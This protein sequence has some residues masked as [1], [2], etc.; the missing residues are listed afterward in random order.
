MFRRY[1]MMQACAE[2][3]ELVSVALIKNHAFMGV[4]GCL[5]NLFGL[6]PGEFHG[7]RPRHYYHHLV[8]MPY[9]LADLGRLYDP[10]LNIV[11]ALV[12]QAGQEW[13]DGEGAGRVVNGLIAGDHVV[14]TDA[15]M[16][17]I[18]G[19]DSRADWPQQPF[20]R[21]RNALKIA[22]DGGFGTVDLEQI[23]FE[24]EVEPAAEGT[25]YARRTDSA[26]TNYSWLRSMCEQAHY[27]QANRQEFVDRYAGQFIL[28]QQG[29]VRWHS[30][31]GTVRESRRKLAGANPD[32]AMWLK[33]VDPDEFEGEHFEVYDQTLERLAQAQP[34]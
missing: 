4:T 20:L 6:M 19:H 17:H 31:E 12:G 7:G 22:A 11:D 29:E 16:M 14:A 25:F 10:A 23:D 24:S 33:Y 3:D 1:Q 21:D 30:P 32:Q 9:H 13:G 2:A 5:K 8:R 34:A 28:L 27:Y 15:C 18:M 26:E